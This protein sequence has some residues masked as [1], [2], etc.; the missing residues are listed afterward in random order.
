MIIKARHHTFIYPFFQWYSRWIIKRNFDRVIIHGE[1]VDRDLS[2]LLVSN[3]ISWWDGFWS[4]YLNLELFKRKFHFM[5]L[6]NQ[7][8]KYWYFNFSGGYSVEQNSRSALESIDYTIELLSHSENLV[9]MFPQ[10]KLQSMHRQSFEFRKGIERI[11]EKVGRNNIQ[12][13]FLVNITEYLSR[14]KPTLHQYI[15]E[16]AGNSSS[17]EDLQFY[18]NVFCQKCF[19]QHFNMEE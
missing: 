8:R 1:F 17:V 16:Y 11:V 15:M 3:H 10:G 2:V 9:L 5:M 19:E 6:K 4:M 14:Q 13:V 18:Y 7:L 12:L